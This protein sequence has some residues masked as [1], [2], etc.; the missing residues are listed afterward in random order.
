[1]SAG[2]VREL[3]IVADRLGQ[4]VNDQRLV[5]VQILQR[6]ECLLDP[7]QHLVRCE[8][9]A[10]PIEQM[11]EIVVGDEHHHQELTGGV[12]EEIHDPVQYEVSCA[13]LIFD[14]CSSPL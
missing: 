9:S 13:I 5:G 10:A 2:D 14:N 1:M 6:I 11:C 7:A 3:G 4:V 8:W 12:G